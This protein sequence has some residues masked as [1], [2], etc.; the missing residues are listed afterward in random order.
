MG[1]AAAGPERSAALR[2]GEE[3]RGIAG[4]D[5]RTVEAVSLEVAGEVRGC[6]RCGRVDQ[7][8][9]V[10]AVVREGR[11]SAVVRG[12]VTGSPGFDLPF[13]AH[14][15][16]TTGLAAQLAPPRRPMSPAVPTTALVLLGLIEF[17]VVQ[18]AVAEHGRYGTGALAGC[19]AV[20]VGVCAVLAWWWRCEAARRGQLVDR[21]QYLWRRCWYCR[22]CGVVSVF[23]AA[24]PRVLAAGNLAAG[25]MD[26]A[27]Q[28]TWQKRA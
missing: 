9:S 16:G 13:R 17:G 2:A 14:S 4:R 20:V 27:G 12:R 21:A 7:I 22:R 15:V 8:V 6:V 3:N 24:G 25:L 19:L 23:T 11:S 10:P 1:M 26:L 5:G 28:L 18:A